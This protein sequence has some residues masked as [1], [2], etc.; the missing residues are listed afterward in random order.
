MCR[1]GRETPRIYLTTYPDRQ[2]RL[3]LITY[4]AIY[5]RLYEHGSFETDE[6]AVRSQ[7]VRTP[8]V[9]EHVLHDI[10]N[11]P[12][13]SFRKVA[14]LHSV[15]QRTVICILHENRCYVCHLQRAQGLSPVDFPPRQRFCRWF[16][17]QAI[18][19]MGFLSLVLIASLTYIIVIC[20]LQTILTE[21]LKRPISR[22]LASMCV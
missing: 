7:T 14:R 12:G 9:E 19:T 3:H 22:G 21:W 17:Q 1:N 5:R 8:D 6:S 11:N 16:M 2:H 10:D 15:S 20:G 18:T 13:A 4:G